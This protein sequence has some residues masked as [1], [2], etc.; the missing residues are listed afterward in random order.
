[1]LL[2]SNTLSGVQILLL[3]AQQVSQCLLCSKMHRFAAVVGRA[4]LNGV[5]FSKQLVA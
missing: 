1:M 2:L 5:A 4:C 3:S